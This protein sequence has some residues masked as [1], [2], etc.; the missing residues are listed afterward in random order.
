MWWAWAPGPDRGTL[1]VGHEWASLPNRRRMC[2][3]QAGGALLGQWEGLLCRKGGERARALFRS[4]REGLLGQ[5][6]SE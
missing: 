4:G 5:G 3:G 1:L 2:Q 6:Q